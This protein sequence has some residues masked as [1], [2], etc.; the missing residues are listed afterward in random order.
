MPD[1]YKL[2]EQGLPVYVTNK[3]AGTILLEFKRQGVK[4]MP[5]EAR[6]PP[7]SDY[8]VNVANFVPYPV[9]K[10][11]STTLFTWLSKGLLV[12]HDPEV[13]KHM[14]E[15]EPEL[16]AAVNEVV[17]KA[18]NRKGFVTKDLGFGVAPGSAEQAAAIFGKDVDPVERALSGKP[19][20]MPTSSSTEESIHPRI[21]QMVVS[22]VE[23][24][25]LQQETL[26]HLRV[27][28][29]EQLNEKSLGFLINKC[30]AFP[31]IVKWAKGAL[32]KRKGEDAPDEA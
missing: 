28:S 17:S 24:A 4:T 21:T 2:L 22:L 11:D 18:N 8:P 32:A 23:D 10:E 6:I 14:Y 19:A 3:S 13:V 26:S 1:L 12:L 7:I 30:K 5:F 27:M 16:E 29:R 25:S 31:S 9:L 20:P 15:A